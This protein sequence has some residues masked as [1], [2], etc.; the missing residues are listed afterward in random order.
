MTENDIS[1][2]HIYDNYYSEKLYRAFNKL[3]QDVING[4]VIDRA[5]SRKLL[6]NYTD[7]FKKNSLST[8]EKKVI[9]DLTEEIFN[10]NDNVTADEHHTLFIE[11]FRVYL[12]LQNV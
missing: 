12:L 4:I 5:N 7:L 10:E 1:K 3:T 8:Y 6:Y 9:Y 2:Y 11:K